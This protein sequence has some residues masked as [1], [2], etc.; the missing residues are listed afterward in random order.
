MLIV[1]WILLII[2][3]NIIIFA[4]KRIEAGTVRAKELWILKGEN[5][6]IEDNIVRILTVRHGW[7]KYV[8]NSD[9]QQY[10]TKYQEFKRIY[11]KHQ[12]V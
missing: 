4:I 9:N 12:S 8:C 6:F 2:V 3:I 11:E 10:H 7:I 1:Y 5:P